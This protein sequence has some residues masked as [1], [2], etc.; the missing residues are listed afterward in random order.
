MQM[1]LSWHLIRSVS[2]ATCFLL[3][4]CGTTAEAQSGLLLGLH[5]ESAE[6]GSE[7]PHRTLWIAPQAGTLQIM[8]LPDLIVPR[9]TGFWRVGTRFYCNPDDVKNE[10]HREPSPDGALFAA[11]VNQRPVVDGVVQCPAHVQYLDTQGVCGDNVPYGATGIDVSFVNDGYISLDSWWRTD[12][13]GGH[14]DAGGKRSVEKLGDPARD[15]ITYGDIEGKGASDEYERRAADALIDNDSRIDD[16]GHRVPLGE[17]DTEED[18]EIREKLPNW[19]SMNGVEKV[20]AMQTLDLHDGCFPKHDDKEWY[21]VRNHGEWRAYGNFGTHR[22]CGVEVDFELPF[23]AR[24][25]APAMAPISLDAIKNRITIKDVS[26]LKTIKGVTDVFWSPN[27]DFLV[28]LVD[29]DKSCINDR[30][31]YCPPLD[32]HSDLL[33]QTLLQVYSPRGQ[34][35]GKPAISML[36]KEFERP[37][38]AEWATGSNVA[39]WTAELKKIKAQG[40]VKPLL[41]SSSHP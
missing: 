31:N 38:M 29:M 4:V 40:V 1:G 27:H 8:E 36:L 22:L 41:S 15:P 12:C 20:I 34:D 13:G 19:F 6:D 26:D 9:K 39:R 7:I 2:A 33:D 5:R 37:V 17:G 16:D 35:L 30:F 14:P 3:A 24:F 10:P 28:V 11:P 18:K 25:A 21:I 23:H 32:P